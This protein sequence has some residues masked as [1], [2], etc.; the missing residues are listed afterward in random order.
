MFSTPFKIKLDLQVHF[1]TKLFHE[2]FHLFFKFCQV[3]LIIAFLK[4]SAAVFP[5]YN[6]YTFLQKKRQVHAN[7]FLFFFQSFEG[8]ELKYKAM[9]VLSY[10][11]SLKKKKSHLFLPLA[12]RTDVTLSTV[13]C[14]FQQYTMNLLLLNTPHSKSDSESYSNL[15]ALPAPWLLSFKEAVHISMRQSH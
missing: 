9:V 14:F 12:W 4:E 2:C 6:R 8:K 1:M 10:Q 3:A 7:I 5:L 13:C 11:N 15:L